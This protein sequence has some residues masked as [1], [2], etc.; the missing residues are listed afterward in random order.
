MDNIWEYEITPETQRK[1]ENRMLKDSRGMRRTH[2]VSNEL[3]EAWAHTYYVSM[4]RELR[5]QCKR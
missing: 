3:L 5:R 4:L 1:L 2:K